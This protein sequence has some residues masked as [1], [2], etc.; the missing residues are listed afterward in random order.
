MASAGQPPDSRLEEARAVG[1]PTRRRHGQSHSRHRLHSSER[2]P[3]APRHWGLSRVAASSGAGRALGSGLRLAPTAPDHP[4]P[5]PS[6]RGRAVACTAPLWLAIPPATDISG[7]G[8]CSLTFMSADYGIT[9]EQLLPT[10]IRSRAVGRARCRRNRVQS[11]G[12]PT[13]QGTNSYESWPCPLTR[14]TFRHLPWHG[15][16]HAT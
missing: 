13:R 6:L 4:V 16:Q 8:H 2:A 1:R 5:R 11:L 3:A 7:R 15:N 10:P 14:W 12:I 9:C